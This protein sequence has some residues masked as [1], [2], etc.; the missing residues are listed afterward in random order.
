MREPI[1]D[2]RPYAKKTEK[3]KSERARKR[4]REKER[5]R[6]KDNNQLK[7]QYCARIFRLRMNFTG[8]LRRLVTMPS[9]ICKT[10]LI[11][12]RLRSILLSNHPSSPSSFFWFIDV[13]KREGEREIKRG[14]EKTCLFLNVFSLTPF[15]PTHRGR[16][17]NRGLEKRQA[18]L[19]TTISYQLTEQ[20]SHPLHAESHFR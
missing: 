9:A 1:V 20:T 7:S 17:F 5:T 4:E 18:F 12:Y 11:N 2:Y 6:R 14:K 3:R 15:V 13:L 16:N 19:Q 10:F 8:L